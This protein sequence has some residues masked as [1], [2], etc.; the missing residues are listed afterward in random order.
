MTTIFKSEQGLLQLEVTVEVVPV[1]SACCFKGA[2][3]QDN[4][5]KKNVDSSHKNCLNRLNNDCSEECVISGGE[6]LIKLGIDVA[7]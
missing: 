4:A 5:Q 3:L 6:P 7:G 1:H 2:K